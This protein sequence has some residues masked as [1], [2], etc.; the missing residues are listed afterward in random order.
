MKKGKFDIFDLSNIDKC[1]LGNKILSLPGHSGGVNS[2]D[3]GEFDEHLLIST[4]MDNRI[5]VWLKDKLVGDVN[6]NVPI[7]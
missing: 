5:K 7:P 3:I 4:G 1:D 6:A 2:L